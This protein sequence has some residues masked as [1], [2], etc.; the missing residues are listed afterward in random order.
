MFCSG[1]G[2]VGGSGGGGVGVVFGFAVYVFV[3]GFRGVWDR[4]PKNPKP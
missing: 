4:D 2:W 3:L 1:G